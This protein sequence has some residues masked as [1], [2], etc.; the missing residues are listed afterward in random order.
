MTP[1][2]PLLAEST[3]D[4]SSSLLLLSE[5]RLFHSNFGAA[6]AKGQPPRLASVFVCLLCRL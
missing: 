3:H 2:L 4:K 5:N 1:C 6:L